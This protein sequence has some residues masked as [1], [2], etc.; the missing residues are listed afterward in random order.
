MRTEV[1]RTAELQHIPPQN[2]LNRMRSTPD[3]G[4]TQ[5]HAIRGDDFIFFAR[6]FETVQ[7]SVHAHSR[8]DRT[9]CTYYIPPLMHHSSRSGYVVSYNLELVDCDNDEPT[10]V[11]KYT[12][13]FIDIVNLD[14][15]ELT[16]RVYCGL[17]VQHS[18]VLNTVDSTIAQYTGAAAEMPNLQCIIC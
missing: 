13:K 12:T 1:F 9:Q 10:T 5:Y 7:K 8:P 4:K 14:V 3:D 2:V 15:F 11:Q 16:V 18:L 6:D 17:N